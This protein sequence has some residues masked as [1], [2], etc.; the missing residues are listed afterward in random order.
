[1]GA[2]RG[3]LQRIIYLFFC[4]RRTRRA[5]R[6]RL[7]PVGKPKKKKNF[8]FFFSSFGLNP[9]NVRGV[10]P[11]EP[12]HLLPPTSHLLPP[13]FHLLTPT[14]YLYYYIR[15]LMSLIPLFFFALTFYKPLNY[16]TCEKEDF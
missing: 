11:W 13:T 2:L 8:F 1:V 10:K 12:P 9:A 7:R 16:F 4:C 3:R 5:S 6:G 14:S 15:L